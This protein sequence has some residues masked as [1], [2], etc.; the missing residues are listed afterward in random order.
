MGVAPECIILGEVTFEARN[1]YQTG[2]KK[3]LLLLGSWNG[4]HFTPFWVTLKVNGV[5]GLLKYY[6]V[7]CEFFFLK[8]YMNISHIL[9]DQTNVLNICLVFIPLRENKQQNTLHEV[10]NIGSTHFSTIILPK[11]NDPFVHRPKYPLSLV[12]CRNKCFV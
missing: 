5:G 10:N 4:R 8:D 9:R 2:V 1:D 12:G 3:S 7:L 6:Q 11:L